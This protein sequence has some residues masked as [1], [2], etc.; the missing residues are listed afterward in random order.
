MRLVCPR[1]CLRC[2]FRYKYGE[3][4]SGKD[5]GHCVA[6]NFFGTR[7]KN[8]LAGLIPASFFTS[9]LPVNPDAPSTTLDQMRGMRYLANNEVPLHRYFNTD[10]VKVL[11][12]QEGVPI[13]SRGIYAAPVPWRPM[14]GVL[15]CSNHPLVLN[16]EQQTDSGNGRR[17]LYSRM[18]RESMIESSND[19]KTA[20]NS[21]SLNPEMFWLAKKFYSYLV[22]MPLSTRL[23]PIPPRIAAETAELLS[24]KKMAELKAWIEDDANTKPAPAIAQ[25]TLARVVK[26]KVAD[27]F[28]IDLNAA[29]AL[30]KSA[31]T[32]TKR[33]GAGIFML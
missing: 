6:L 33:I 10:A 23:H 28:K 24:S 1:V 30:L 12:E 32:R 31:G 21:G 5:V 16:D 14:G 3:G 19:V 2:E 11:A 27:V 4:G 26:E 9:S 17:L 15:C 18:R 8:G 7:D 29:D 20:I 22:R 25:G 13:L